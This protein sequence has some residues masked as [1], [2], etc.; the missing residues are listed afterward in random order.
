[1]GDIL[2]P[3]EKRRKK[4]SDYPWIRLHWADLFSS[5]ENL[6]DAE[7]RAIF[8]DGYK[9]WR[10]CDI[11][12]MPEPIKSCAEEIES[13]NLLRGNRYD[14]CCTTGTGTSGTEPLSLSLSVSSLN[15]SLSPDQE[16]NA[17]D[18]NEKFIPCTKINAAQKMEAHASGWQQAADRL[19]D[20]GPT[21]W[22]SQRKRAQSAV[23]AE[24]LNHGATIE[25]LIEQAGYY[26]TACD[27]SGRLVSAVYS[28]LEKKQYLDDWKTISEQQP[29]E[30]GKVANTR[31]TRH[32]ADNTRKNADAALSEKERREIF[33]KNG[34]D[35][36]YD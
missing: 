11:E 33:I 14:L 27:K 16:K 31:S 9:A 21:V 4:I 24:V 7:F 8:R 22:K 25:H 17:C 34:L 35:P 29:E 18:D 13:D 12:S 6:T 30:R 36:D 28:W 32:N 1:L 23:V 3:K 19:C 20:A 10:K 15:S 5:T 26:R 2:I